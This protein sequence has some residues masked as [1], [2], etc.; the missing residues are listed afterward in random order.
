[1]SGGVGVCVSVMSRFSRF[2]ECALKGMQNK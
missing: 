2:C 1:M